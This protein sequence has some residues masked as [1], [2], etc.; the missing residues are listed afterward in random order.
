MQDLN[1]EIS[2]KLGELL[3]RSEELGRKIDQL[4]EERGGVISQIQSLIKYLRDSGAPPPLI[5]TRVQGI[6]PV[7][8][9]LSKTKAVKKLLYPDRRFK[10]DELHSLMMSKGYRFRSKRPV[11]DLASALRNSPH[12]ERDEDRRW[13][14]VD[15]HEEW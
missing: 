9:N 3:D 10:T 8:V 6:D 14:L 1:R 11:R 5:P 4:E 7:F 13:S 12:F 2:K 15:P